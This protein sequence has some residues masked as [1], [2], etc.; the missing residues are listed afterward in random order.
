MY[1]STGGAEEQRQFY[2]TP[3][4]MMM[5]RRRRRWWFFPGRYESFSMLVRVCVGALPTHPHVHSPTHTLSV[6]KIIWR[7][8]RTK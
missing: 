3:P 1:R 8:E 7:E 5:R 2:R 6:L 4:V